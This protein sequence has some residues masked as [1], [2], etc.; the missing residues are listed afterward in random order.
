MNFKYFNSGLWKKWQDD[1]KNKLLKEFK[2]EGYVTKISLSY[3]DMDLFNDPY[4][5]SQVGALGN[6][7]TW[8]QEHPLI[9]TFQFDCEKLKDVNIPFN[10]VS[11]Y[12]TKRIKEGELKHNFMFVYLAPFPHLCGT[13]ILTRYSIKRREL[14]AL[15]PETSTVK[16]TPIFLQFFV[17]LATLMGF[18]SIMGSNIV[19]SVDKDFESVEQI[20]KEVPAVMARP[21]HEIFKF[22]VLKAGFKTV[23][24]Y[25]NP[26]SNNVVEVW[27][28]EIKQNTK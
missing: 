13:L 21:K 24:R 7:I 26:R 5:S 20:K 8:G 10:S 25:R 14:L 18:G 6:Y 17:E 2:L 4:N 22:N 11:S 16:F 3:R 9:L 23:S 28:Y 15:I 27:S 1:W 12:L 19:N